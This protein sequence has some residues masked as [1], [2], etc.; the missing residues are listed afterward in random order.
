[1]LDEEVNPNGKNLSG[2]LRKHVVEAVEGGQSRRA[3]A[4]Q[5][6]IGPHWAENIKKLC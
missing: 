1:V 2:D 6:N 3:T 4:Q 5:F